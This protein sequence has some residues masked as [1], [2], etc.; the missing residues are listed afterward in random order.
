MY[1]ILKA[2]NKKRTGRYQSASELAVDLRNL[3][4]E[5]EVEARLKRSTASTAGAIETTSNSFAVA[6]TMLNRIAHTNSTEPAHRN[7]LIELLTGTSRHSKVLAAIVLVVV[8]T[9]IGWTYFA[10]GPTNLT[11]F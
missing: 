5:L 4:D 3:K 10:Q 8:A 7:T 9:V 2:L 6:E 11:Q 1:I